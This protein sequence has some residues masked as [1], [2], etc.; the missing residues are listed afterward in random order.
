MSLAFD[1]ARAV[2]IYTEKT[3][4]FP[5]EET[6]FNQYLAPPKLILDLGCGTGRT[7]RHLT[8]MGNTVFGMD[9]SPQMI[10]QA[11]HLH[12]DIVFKTADACDIPVPDE[13]FDAV[14]FSFNGLDYI[15]PEDNRIKALKEIHRILAPGGIFIFSTHDVNGIRQQKRNWR[16]KPRRYK[17]MYFKENTVYGELI[18]YYGSVSRNLNNLRACGFQDPKYYDNNGKSWRYYTAWKH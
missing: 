13:S 18:T 4:L 5:I 15:Y 2:E 11:Q 10:K 1:N 6:I 7:T 8:D 16:R 12:P 9:I 17:G 14:V 3:S